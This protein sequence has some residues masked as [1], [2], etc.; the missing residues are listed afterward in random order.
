MPKRK[1]YIPPEFAYVEECKKCLLHKGRKNV[2]VGRGNIHAKY[3]LIGEAPG[4]D[5]DNSGM[6]FVGKS[7]ARLNEMLKKAGWEEDDLYITNIVCCR[8]PKNRKPSPVEIKACFP[9]LHHLISIMRPTI[10]ILVGGTALNYFMPKE[11][12]TE[13]HG[14]LLT[15]SKGLYVYPIIHPAAGLR[16][17]P[18]YF[19]MIAADLKKLKTLKPPSQAAIYIGPRMIRD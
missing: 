1:V 2:V 16:G 8:P 7:G 19:K 13:C 4:E 5:E 6:P 18:E 3:L 10:I 15:T 11:R 17:N 14:K 9:R 12:I